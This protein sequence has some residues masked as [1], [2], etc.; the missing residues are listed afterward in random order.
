MDKE[1]D[2]KKEEQEF[3]ELSDTT[4]QDPGDDREDRDEDLEERPSIH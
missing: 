2:N 1:R 4:G 3:P